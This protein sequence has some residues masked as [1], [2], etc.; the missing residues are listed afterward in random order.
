LPHLHTWQTITS[1]GFDMQVVDPQ[2]SGRVTN[3]QRAHSQTVDAREHSR[4][5]TLW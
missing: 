4:K 3:T 2:A 5:L 1:G